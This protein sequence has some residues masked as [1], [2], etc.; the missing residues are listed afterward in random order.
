M[1][2]TSDISEIMM[3]MKTANPRIIGIDGVDGSGK[4]TLPELLSQEMD[5]IHLNV[6]DYLE[7][8]RGHFVKYIKYD[9]IQSQIDQAKKPVIIEGVCLLA[10]FQRLQRNPD[11]FIYVKRVSNGGRWR[12][13][14]DCEVTEN[15]DNFMDQKK[16]NFQ[17]FVMAEASIEGRDFNAK[18]YEFPSLDEEIIRYH[19]EFKPHKKADIIY[20]RID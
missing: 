13:K 8:N 4:S 17:K 18:D 20:K 6:D 14:D 1:Y 19:Y 12:D 10:V 9:A 11:M 5:Y 15:I 7:K 3:R 2:E 16:E